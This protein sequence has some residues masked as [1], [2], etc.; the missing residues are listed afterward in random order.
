MELRRVQPRQ[1]DPPSSTRPRWISNVG[2]NGCQLLANCVTIPGCSPCQAFVPWMCSFRKSSIESVPCGIGTI[3]EKINIKVNIDTC[4]TP[5][6]TPT[7]VT[8]P[9]VSLKT[10]PL[11]WR[12]ERQREWREARQAAK[13]FARVCE[14]GDADQL[15]NAHL[16]LN[17]CSPVAWRLA[18]KNVGKLQKVSPDVQNAF[19]DIWVDLKVLPLRVGDRP[20]LA[21]HSGS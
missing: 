6:R 18:M 4:V 10:V 17:E 13:A 19:P 3:F 7:Q 1:E 14:L 12:R 5:S 2:K 9:N 11:E 16:L 21:R 20:T 8:T 15:Y